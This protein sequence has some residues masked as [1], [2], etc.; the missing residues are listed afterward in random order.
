MRNLA[1]AEAAGDDE[2][3]LP[4]AACYSH[5]RAAAHHMETEPALKAKIE[6][7]LGYHFDGSIRIK[8]VLDTFTERVGLD[9]IERHV[10]RPLRGLKVVCYYGCLLTRPPRVTKAGDVE[11]PTAMDRMMR[12]LG[13][14]TLDWSYKT[15]CCGASL[16]ITQTDRVL[17]LTERILAN[18]KAVGADAVVV[19]CS[20]CH[21][22]LDMRQQ[23]IAERLGKQYNIPVIYFTQLMGLAFGLSPKE[24]G[25]S[26]H[27]T[28]VDGLLRQLGV[29][30]A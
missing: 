8:N 14:E 29:A 28:K 18:A 10:T 7:K 4:C 6:H 22:N 19:A 2:V 13:M 17:G 23:D 16:M 24:L 21:L 26:K 15:E 11:N 9:E 20:S 3:T 30:G 1:M 5:F 25:L 12:R 27:F